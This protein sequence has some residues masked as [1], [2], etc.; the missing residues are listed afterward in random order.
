M[1]MRTPTT[2]TRM[3]RR[4][5]RAAAGRKSQPRREDSSSRRSRLRLRPRPGG[6]PAGSRALALGGTRRLVAAGERGEVSEVEQRLRHLLLL[7]ARHLRL[8]LGLRFRPRAVL[9]VRGVRVGAFQDCAEETRGWNAGDAK[10]SEEVRTSRRGAKGKRSEK[11]QTSAFSEGHT[12]SSTDEARG[13]DRRKPPRKSGL[14]RFS[15]AKKRR[16]TLG[17][18]PRE[19]G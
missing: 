16:T 18:K 5:R 14:A 11:T 1:R 8:G 12:K 19:R 2:T 4:L 13:V 17:W 3:R 9:A 15:M 7:L 6:T 10:G